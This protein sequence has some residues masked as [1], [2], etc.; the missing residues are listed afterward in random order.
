VI[1]VEVGHLGRYSEVVGREK[2][3]MREILKAM[4][5]VVGDSKDGGCGWRTAVYYSEIIK[6]D[7]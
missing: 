5:N 1:D 3:S 2:S 4:L 7:P 6:P